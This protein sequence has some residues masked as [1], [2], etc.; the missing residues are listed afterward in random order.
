MD[1][2]RVPAAHGRRRLPPLNALRAFEAVARHLSVTLAADELSVTPAAVSQ[3]IRQLE[4]TLGTPLVR[5]QGRGLA[6]TEAGQALLPGL[7]E[8]F[9]RLVQALGA[10]PQSAEARATV[11]VAVTPSF[12]DKWLLPR[13]G[14]FIQANPGLDVHVIAGME[15]IDLQRE[16]VDLAVRFGTGQYAGLSVALLRE[17][18]VFPVC[19]P[20]LLTGPTPLRTLPD[21]RHHVL[22]HDDN[23][24]ERGACPDWPLW[25]TAA[26]HA[27]LATAKGPRFNQSSMVLDAAA[28]G[29]GVALA[30][31]FL[32]Q[33]DLEAGRLVRPFPEN[34]VPRFAYWIVATAQALDRP[35]VRLLRDWL[36]HEANP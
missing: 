28:Q 19:A 27:P 14:G 32:A 5:R 13:L 2:S 25:L 29:L 36:L 31:G 9:D 6:L 20:A 21:L 15:V 34:H 17:E 16:A 22:I 1:P 3:Q 30:K 7:S 4:E 24:A 18:E 11:R 12:A 33:T 10:M 8:G 23:P 35:A 26:G